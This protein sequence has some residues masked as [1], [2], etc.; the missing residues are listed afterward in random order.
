VG[1]SKW[2]LPLAA[3]PLFAAATIRLGRRLHATDL[4]E[5][6]QLDSRLWRCMSV[7]LC[8]VQK[9]PAATPDRGT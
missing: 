2:V 3:L 1:L 7:N 9:S 8:L 4:R 5:S 6:R